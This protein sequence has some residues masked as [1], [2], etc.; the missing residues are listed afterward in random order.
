MRDGD[1]AGFKKCVLLE[2]ER[3][4]QRQ[5]EQERTALWVV[6]TRYHRL[7][8]EE[9]ANDANRSRGQAR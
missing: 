4:G 3:L 6:E 5:K 8:K 9:K 7:Q 1:L 2:E